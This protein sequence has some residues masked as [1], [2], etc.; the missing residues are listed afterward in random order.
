MP[1]EVTGSTFLFTFFYYSG[2]ELSLITL[3]G[4]YMF[5]ALANIPVM[6]FGSYL[7]VSPL[8]L[9]LAPAATAFLF[10]NICG[11]N[12]NL[13]SSSSLSLPF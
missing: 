6:V 11:T 10:A 2:D 13:F 5:L 12:P 4:F 9:A 1:P 8:L 3:F 7:T